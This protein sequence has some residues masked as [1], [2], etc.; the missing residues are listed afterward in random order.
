M[1]GGCTEAREAVSTIGS[2]C[3]RPSVTLA[4]LQGRRRG[5]AIVRGTVYGIQD[6][7][8]EAGTLQIQYAGRPY[9]TDA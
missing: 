3:G 5:Q 4:G 6:A 7:K 1:L 2:G 8:V 9:G